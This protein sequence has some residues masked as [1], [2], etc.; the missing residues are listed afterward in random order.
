MIDLDYMYLYALVRHYIVD[1][2]IM[3]IDGIMWLYGRNRHVVA[4]MKWCVMILL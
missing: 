3:C 4:C 2:S 1:T